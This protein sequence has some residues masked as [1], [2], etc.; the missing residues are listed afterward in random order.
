[1]ATY[2]EEDTSITLRQGTAFGFDRRADLGVFLPQWGAEEAEHARALHALLQHQQY[3]RPERMV[4]TDASRSRRRTMARLPLHTIGRARGVALL[5]CTMG[6]AAEYVA[7][8][9][10][11][12]L[13]K[14]CDDPAV[15]DL[16]RAIARQEARHLAFFLAGARACGERMSRAH[17]RASR[18]ALRALWEPI[19]MP[20]LGED[21]WLALFGEW[22]HDQ[23][24]RA[25]LEKMDR[26]VDS[27]PHLDGL[28]LMG[29]FLAR[30]SPAGAGPGAQN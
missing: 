29:T 5:F 30:V 7:T 10:Y 9:L 3:E 18:M 11:S 14:R 23:R 22:L 8:M 24:L 12:D 16:L 25:R 26:V 13:A 28:R 27:V 15:A 19:G 17:G 21:L 2:L 6:A 4:I 1:M 20:T